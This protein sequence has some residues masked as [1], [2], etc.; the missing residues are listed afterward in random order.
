[1][2]LPRR[3]ACCADAAADF[4]KKTGFPKISDHGL[5]DVFIGGSGISGKVHIESTDR[6]GSVFHVREV[7]VKIDTLKF[8]LRDTKHN[9]LYATIRPL[10]TGLIKKRA[11][12]LSSAGAQR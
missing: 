6:R 3:S 12:S 10:A 1:M 2:R 9:F 7:K 11:S 5:A 4:K 8:K